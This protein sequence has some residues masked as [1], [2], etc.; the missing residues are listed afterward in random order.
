MGDSAGSIP[1]PLVP[2]SDSLGVFGYFPF[3]VE[4][5]DR[6][7]GYA[8]QHNGDGYCSQCDGDNWLRQALMDGIHQV[9]DRADAAN[10]EPADDTALIP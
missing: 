1:T 9:I 10:A 6:L 3:P 2:R 4:I 5:H 8:V 7:H